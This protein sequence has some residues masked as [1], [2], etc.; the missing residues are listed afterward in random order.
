MCPEAEA[1]GLAGGLSGGGVVLSAGG[2]V[3][4]L[5]VRVAGCW[6]SIPRRRGWLQRL[7][8]QSRLF[9]QRNS[10]RIYGSLG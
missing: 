3:H 7:F 10:D 1:P 6:S 9:V 5:Y 4:L 8:V 2:G